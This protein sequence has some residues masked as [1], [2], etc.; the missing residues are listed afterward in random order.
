MAKSIES[1]KRVMENSIT[2]YTG[3]HEADDDN[4]KA[5]LQCSCGCGNSAGWCDGSV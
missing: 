1:R 2:E 4:T 5:A 3:A